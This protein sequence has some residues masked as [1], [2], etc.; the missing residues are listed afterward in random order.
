MN[1]E[2]V[3][4]IVISLWGTSGGAA[5]GTV[6]QTSEFWNFGLRS[7]YSTGSEVEA[8]PTSSD[9]K[10]NLQQKNLINEFEQLNQ[11]QTQSKMLFALAWLY[12]I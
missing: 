6:N 7:Y 2:S 5:V 4:A 10:R 1:C 11:T 9:M 8:S 12:I 3:A